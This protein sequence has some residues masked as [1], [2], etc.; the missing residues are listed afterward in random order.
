MSV[1][2]LI[3]RDFIPTAVNPLTAEKWV[4]V[5]EFSV[6]VF[7]IDAYVESNARVFKSAGRPSGIDVFLTRVEKLKWW[8]TTLSIPVLVAACAGVLVIV[9]RT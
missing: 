4:L 2:G 6:L 1:G 7:A 5:A 8:V 3:F 9:H